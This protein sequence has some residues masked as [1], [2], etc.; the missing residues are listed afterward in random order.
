MRN[1]ALTIGVGAAVLLTGLA[2]LEYGNVE[3][4]GLTRFTFI[5]LIIIGVSAICVGVNGTFF[6]MEDPEEAQVQLG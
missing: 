3:A 2:Q 1:G 4:G 5:F 6:G